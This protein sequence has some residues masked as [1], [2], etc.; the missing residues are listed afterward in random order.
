MHLIDSAGK[1]WFGIAWGNGH[2]SIF[3]NSVAIDDTTIPYDFP[4]TTGDVIKLAVESGEFKLYQNGVEKVP[5]QGVSL[6]P[7]DTDLYGRVQLYWS[8]A[9]VSASFFQ[10]Q[11]IV[12]S[13]QN[14]SQV[15][16]MEAHPAFTAPVDLVSALDFVDSLCASDTQDAGDEIIFLTPATPSPR[17]SVFTFDESSNVIDLKVY[18]RDIRERPNR[19]SA[20]FR[21][22]NKVYLDQD[23]VFDS[24]DT[25]FDE[26]GY[27]VDPGALNFASMNASQA[28][29]L[30]RYQM[31]RL[32]D[33]DFFCDVVGMADSFKLLPGDIVTVVSEKMPDGA[34][35]DFIIITATRESGE[36]TA[37]ERTFTL[38]EW[39]ADDYSDTDHGPEQ[40][41]I[42]DPL[43]SPYEPPDA[44]VVV[45]D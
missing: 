35:K 28:Q 18:R 1:V 8:T 16:R 19:L 33:N 25:L 32:S 37:Y 22:I 23:E 12:T 40:A 24:R 3:A 41:Q 11:T 10:G 13:T 4:A 30:I 15:K 9:A 2:L 14:V 38:Q 17:T 39:Y 29:R 6:V 36:S 5:P 43:P 44:P 42:T 27:T 31:R 45:I 34:P 21:N 7:L 26:V 20:Q